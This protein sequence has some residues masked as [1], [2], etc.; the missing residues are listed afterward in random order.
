[1]SAPKATAPRRSLTGACPAA[2][3]LVGR[4]NRLRLK[5]RRFYHRSYP[6]LSTF[7]IDF[8]VHSYLRSRFG[9]DGSMGA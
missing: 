1:M 7:Y 9:P 4:R 3:R 8:L 5:M 2:R 6:E